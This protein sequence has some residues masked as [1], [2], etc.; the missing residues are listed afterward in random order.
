MVNCS[1]R[2][3]AAIRYVDVD[4]VRDLLDSLYRGYPS[5]LILMRQTPH[6]SRRCDERVC[7]RSQRGKGGFGVAAARWQRLTSLSSVLR[8]SP[9]VSGTV[10][11]LSTFFQSE[12]PGRVDL[13]ITEVDEPDDLMLLMKRSYR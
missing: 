8:A 12:S 11:G 4:E 7:G 1:Y 5:G 9:S 13:H 10:R 6:D 2:D 3:A